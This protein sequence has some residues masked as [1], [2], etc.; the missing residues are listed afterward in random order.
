VGPKSL[1]V[2]VYRKRKTE[3]QER[4]FFPQRIR[5][6]DAL[7]RDF[8]GDYLARVENTIR[9]YSD[10]VQY[11]EYWKAVLKGKTLRQ[12][13]PS[14][15]ERYVAKRIEQVKPASVNRELQF[16]KHV[17]NVAIADGLAD[18]NPVRAVKLFKENNQRIRYL[19]AEEEVRLRKKIGETNWVLVALAVHTGL[20]ESE[21]F[22]LK[23]EHIDFR[24]GIITVPR[25]K[26]G[27]KRHVPM[28]ATVR[29]LLESLPS[30]G[31]SA[32]VFPSATGETPRDA[33]NFMNR[34]FRKALVGAEIA[35]LRWH[36]LRHT[37]ASRLVMAGVDLRTVQELM[38]HKTIAMTVRYSHL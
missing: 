6:R 28:N 31:K 29:E 33:C 36:D 18:T 1:A 34:V 21:Q 13:I 27:E 9:T 20:R 12:V 4:R 3:V 2:K 17:F 38:G 11:G 37:F 14:D 16:L 30:H 23:W 15:I 22:R 24:S 7:V 10:Y 19:T 32:F 26:H 8:I 35:D 25:S 5:R